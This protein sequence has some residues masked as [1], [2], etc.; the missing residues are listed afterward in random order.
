[1]HELPIFLDLQSLKKNTEKLGGKKKK[2]KK[3]R[4][5][6]QEETP[7]TQVQCQGARKRRAFQK[8]RRRKWKRQCPEGTSDLAAGKPLITHR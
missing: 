8:M 6:K 1:M 7:N 3:Q 2:Q 4:S 5:Q